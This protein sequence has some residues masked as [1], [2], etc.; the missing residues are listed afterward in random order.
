MI[1]KMRREKVIIWVI[2]LFI[3]T[4]ICHIIIRTYYYPNLR[5]QFDS[6][7]FHNFLIPIISFLGFIGLIITIIISINQYKSIRSEQYYRYYKDQLESIESKKVPDGFYDNSFLLDFFPYSFNQYVKLQNI[8]EYRDDC[9]VFLSGNEVES[10]SSSYSGNLE[11]IRMFNEQGL[12]LYQSILTLIKEI[13][14]H[15]QLINSHKEL[16]L[17]NLISNLL[18]KYIFNCRYVYS[19]FEE[20]IEDFYL[21]FDS[22]IANKDTLKFFSKRFFELFDY[23]S[24][25]PELIK[26]YEK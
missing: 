4:L 5:L 25:N 10:T 1:H 21:N 13:E 17:D 14:K 26:Y 24:N 23:I 7:E 8:D 18:S 6:T 3:L 2:S 11:E 15:K 19:V 22:K 9:K 12:T 16:L 20:Q